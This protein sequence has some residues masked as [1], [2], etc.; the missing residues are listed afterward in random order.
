[1]KGFALFVVQ[2]NLTGRENEDI[3]E[4]KKGGLA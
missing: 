1:M 4:E 2:F 3:L